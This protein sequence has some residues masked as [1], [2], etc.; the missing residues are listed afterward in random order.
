MLLECDSIPNPPK[1]SSFLEKV[2]QYMKLL[3]TVQGT[4]LDV[5]VKPKSK[6]FKIKTEGDGVTVFCRETPERG[7]VNKELMKELSKIFRKRVEIVSGFASR[8]KRVLIRDASLEEVSR[9]L[10]EQVNPSS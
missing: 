6:A 9:I 10:S 8:Q 2:E 4:I 7:R 1:A 5:H 3:Q